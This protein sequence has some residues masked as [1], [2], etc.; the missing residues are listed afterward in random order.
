M[1]GLKMCKLIVECDKCKKLQNSIKW[2]IK[3]HEKAQRKM[4]IHNP[5]RL[6]LMAENRAFEWTLKQ[7]EK[8]CD[9][10]VINWL[11]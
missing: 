10:E 7:L 9:C 3:R 4:S 1:K 6:D 2:K 11:E 5:I 8:Y